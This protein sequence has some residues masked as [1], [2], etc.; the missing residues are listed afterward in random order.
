MVFDDYDKDRLFTLIYSKVINLFN[1]PLDMFNRTVKHLKKGLD[2]GL[3]T[4]GNVDEFL[5]KELTENIYLFSGAKT[6]QTIRDIQGCLIQDG[7]IIS[8]S[9]FK[10][11]ASEKFDLYNDTYL[12]AEYNT[13]VGQGQMASRWNEIMDNQQTF[14]Y[15]EYSA[16]VDS[17][18]SDICIHL[19]GIVR[20]VN[21]VFWKKYSPLNHFNCRCELMQ[22][23]K[24]DDIE[25][26]PKSKVKE[27]TSKAN[28][29]MSDVFKMNPYFDK[30]VFSE[31]HP[32]FEVPKTYKEWAKK[33]F[34]LPTK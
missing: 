19:D 7:K 17:K 6:F 33:N 20:P 25:Q 2:D 4:Y 14:P 26:T 32:Y 21:D 29:N 3:I 22:V 13:A 1:L 16:V 23:S 8:L 12:T 27:A 30:V 28:E 34:G 15:L 24:Y 9:D 18:T 11:V 31:K 5:I 10:K